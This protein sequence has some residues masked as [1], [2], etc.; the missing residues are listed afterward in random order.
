MSYLRF[1]PTFSI[2]GSVSA[3]RSASS[4]A[5]GSSRGSRSAPGPAGNTPGPPP[6]ERQPDQ[7]GAERV[8]RGRLG[9]EAEPGLP[10]QLGDERGE[11]LGRVDDLV[12]GRPTSASA[13][14][15]SG[16][17][18]S[19][20]RNRWNPHSMQ[21]ALSALTSG[22]LV[23]SASQSRSRSRSS[24]RVDEPPG[25]PGRLGVVAEVLLALGARDLVDVGQQV[26]EVAELLEQ[27]GARLQADAGDA[28]D[29]VRRRRRSAPGGRRPAP[30]ATPQSAF[31]A[32]GVE[33]LLL[34]EVEIR[35]WSSSSWR[36]SLS[37]VQM[38][39]SSPR[40]S[41][42][43]ARVA[44]TSSAS[45]PGC[46]RTGTRNPSKT[47]RMTGICGTRSSGIAARCAL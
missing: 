32:V 25:Q 31:S 11:R 34:A 12:V 10:P 35:T 8:E 46:I 23:R 15:S 33:D 40:S 36:A 42:R 41:P 17:R 47:R 37:A 20:S 44:I 45:T 24:R 26:V 6:T 7:V 16:R 21:R 13:P 22:A 18:R 30:G 5:A 1:W 38:K 2:A 39:T 4:V 19:S 27:L 28:R 9:V 14:P 3:G 29:V 43:R